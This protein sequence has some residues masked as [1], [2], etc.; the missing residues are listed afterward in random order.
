MK[1][2]WVVLLVLSACSPSSATGPA[3]DES[4][5]A[6]PRAPTAGRIVAE[7]RKQL[8]DR[9]FYMAAAAFDDAEAED[10]KRIATQVAPQILA[11]WDAV[12]ESELKN[13]KK[14]GIDRARGKARNN[15]M[16]CERFRELLDK[17]SP[18]APSL[19]AKW[20]A[21]RPEL[22]RA[23]DAAYDLE[24]NDGRPKVLVRSSGPAAVMVQSC[25]IDKLKATYPA[26]QWIEDYDTSG[27]DPK[28]PALVIVAKEATTTY[29]NSQTHEKASLVT[30]MQVALVGH[31][32][33][34]TLAKR[35]A[36][37]LTAQHDVYTPDQVRS[38][39][40]PAKAELVKVGM[41]QLDR[42]REQLCES[43]AETIGST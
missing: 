39:A 38:L 9:D 1:R 40:G 19:A 15:C 4:P 13:A 41:K 21:L 2:P 8:A 25:A 31:N 35:L 3:N 33:D 18:H 23:E 14:L 26:Y 27:S 5:Q 34:K 12:R 28:A 24:A 11:A 22:V 43:L 36:T 7:I 6:A 42:L 17:L 37:P 10:A 30:G 29:A 20:D 16:S 32:L